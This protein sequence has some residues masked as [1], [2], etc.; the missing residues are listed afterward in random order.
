VVGEWVRGYSGGQ[1]ASL[2]ELCPFVCLVEKELGSERGGEGPGS[3]GQSQLPRLGGGGWTKA[4]YGIKFTFG[5]I[6][7]LQ[8]GC[9]DG[10]VPRDPTHSCSV[11]SCG[12]IEETQGAPPPYSQLGTQL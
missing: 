4:S 2:H 1:V 8:E 12:D 10:R 7:G 3:E 9:E 5:T 11:A 6:L